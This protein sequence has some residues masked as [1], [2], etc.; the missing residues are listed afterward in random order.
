MEITQVSNNELAE[1]LQLQYLAYQ[2]E[3]ILYNDF[4]IPPLVQTLEELREEVVESTCLVARR[5]G[6][7]VGSVRARLTEGKCHI[8]RLIVHPE[9]Q[10]QGVGS[11]LMSAIEQYF[12]DAESYEVFTGS[13]S[14]RN[15]TLYER[16]GYRQ[17]GKKQLSEQV[18]LVYLQKNAAAFGHSDKG[19]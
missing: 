4:S 13:R 6:K 9:Y 18:T 2:S 10:G 8:G 16:L 15:I 19:V 1:V 5:Q 14:H 11:K 7:I 12:E 17:T 3:A